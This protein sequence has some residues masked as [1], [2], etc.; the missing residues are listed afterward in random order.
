[1]AVHTGCHSRIKALEYEVRAIKA[2]RTTERK[3]IKG[4]CKASKAEAVPQRTADIKN[5]RLI[6][7]T[8]DLARFEDMLARKNHPGQRSSAT[9]VSQNDKQSEV[10][11]KHD[12]NGQPWISPEYILYRRWFQYNSAVHE[13]VSYTRETFTNAEVTQ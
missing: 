5:Q 13:K 12:S 4:V 1:M 10:T 3:K 9:N 6:G 8:E 11:T 2:N 7:T